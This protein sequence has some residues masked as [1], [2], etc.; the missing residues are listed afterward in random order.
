MHHVGTPT[1]A[2]SFVP[3]TCPNCRAEMTARTYERTYGQPVTIDICDACQGIWFD[4][5]EMLQLSP[6]A[7][8]QVFLHIQEAAGAARQPLGSRLACPR[9]TNALDEAHDM[10]RNT[11]F[12]YFRCGN[13]HG[14]F[15]T[16]FQFLRARNFVRTLTAKEIA[17]LR[18][19]VRQ[20]NCSNCGAPIDINADVACRFCRTPVS[21]LDPDQMRTVALELQ[22]AETPRPVDPTLPLQLLTERR[23]AEEV[24]SN[25]VAQ[26]SLIAVLTRD[27]GTLVDA[28]LGILRALL[29]Q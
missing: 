2:L 17:E 14:R 6:G 27:R 4:E 10:Q 16:F 29:K 28:G 3:M 5:L 8:L 20:V 22:R 7:T 15:T 26:Q 25:G 11:R 13:G 23:R 9:C 24:F 21:M 1:V 18:R 12:T 19:H